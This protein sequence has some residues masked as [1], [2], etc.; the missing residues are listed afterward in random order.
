MAGLIRR[1]QVAGHGSR[2]TGHGL[3]VT[4]HNNIMMLILQ[5]SSLVDAGVLY[6]QLRHM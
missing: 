5:Q 3:Q 1:S 4:G 2:V 6:I